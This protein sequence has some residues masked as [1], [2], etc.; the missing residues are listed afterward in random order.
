MP[1]GRIST[2]LALLGCVTLFATTASA[3]SPATPT[4]GPAAAAVATATGSGTLAGPAVATSAPTGPDYRRLFRPVF[5]PAVLVWFGG[6]L[7]LLLALDYRRFWSLRTVDVLAIILLAV[8][9]EFRHDARP[10]TPKAPDISYAFAAWTALFAL[11][12]Y[13]F[14]RTL[15]QLLRRTAREAPPPGIGAAAWVLL[16]FAVSTNFCTL[17]V[18]DVGERGKRAALGGQYLRETGNLPYGQT[19]FEAAD[20]PLLYMLHAA[21]VK[22][23]SDVRPTAGSRPPTSD[24]STAVGSLPAPG[25]ASPNL[26]AA[27]WISGIAHAL[28]LL[29]IVILGRQYH[30][31]TTGAMLA[32][33][34]GVLAPVAGEVA[35]AP[36]TIPGALVVWALIVASPKART[37]GAVLSGILLAAAAGTMFYAGLL[38]PAWFGYFLRR[39]PAAPTIEEARPIRAASETAADEVLAPPPRKV[40]D[41]GALAFV[42]AFLLVAGA[43]KWYALHKTEPLPPRPDVCLAAIGQASVL[44]THELSILGGRWVL[45]PTSGTTQPPALPSRCPVAPMMRW[46]ADDG[47]PDAGPM[48]SARLLQEIPADVWRQNQVA[49]PTGL[50]LSGP[51]EVALR[52]IR[53]ADPQAARAL[54]V[55]YRQAVSRYSWWQRRI[56]AGRTIF[57]SVFAGETEA[58][59]DVM[60]SRPPATTRPAAAS[61]NQR[62]SAWSEWKRKEYDVLDGQDAGMAARTLARARIARIVDVRRWVFAGYLLLALVLLA[63]MVAFRSRCT[64]FHLGAVSAALILAAQLWRA[65]GGG[66][67]IPWYLPLTMLTLFAG[68]SGEA[69]PSAVANPCRS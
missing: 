55:M 56:A 1:G 42:A 32:G 20:G 36:M 43:V 23:A 6:L 14:L 45:L 2:R 39:R 25:A 13:L 17:P 41:R 60:S 30:S 54:V 12:G 65:D 11:C 10:V 35:I 18:A 24:P 48:L 66:A 57:E 67:D 49:P 64:V 22:P 19:A 44:G 27:R 8:A 52:N 62:W 51:H 61:V 9:F 47:K 5:E 7:W 69:L 31:A 4:G 68:C 15:G 16:A 21:F 50:R 3:Q 26:A 37:I 59:A 46:L 28:L 38:A 58:P 53:P 40:R 29:G 63:V 33:L 34:Y